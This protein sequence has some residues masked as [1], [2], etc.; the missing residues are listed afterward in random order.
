MFIPFRYFN[1]ASLKLGGGLSERGQH[2]VGVMAWVVS[3]MGQRR[4]WPGAGV[5]TTHGAA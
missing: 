5:Q 4:P 1:V 3:L 2:Y